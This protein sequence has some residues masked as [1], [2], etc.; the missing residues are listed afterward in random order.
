ML[1]ALVFWC[2]TALA[3]VAALSATP[4]ELAQSD[5]RAVRAAVEGQLKALAA[6][7][8]D[9]AF[10][11]ATPE[12]RTRFHDAVLFAA[13]VRRSYPM[14]IRPASVSFFL[15]ELNEGMVT[16]SIQ[17]RDHEGNFWRVVYE[18][19]RQPDGGWRINGCAVAPDDDSSTT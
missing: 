8:S 14:L 1:R 2:L 12:I 3:P 11:F 4:P 7:R 18:M 15:P 6:D 16:Q 13:M 9:D 5:A 19:S 10:A 17:V